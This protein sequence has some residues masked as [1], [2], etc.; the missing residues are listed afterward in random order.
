MAPH[1]LPTTDVYCPSASEGDQVCG[2]Q[3]SSLYVQSFLRQT[4]LNKT[5]PNFAQEPPVAITKI[6]AHPAPSWTSTCFIFT[7]IISRFI[8]IAQRTLLLGSPRL[9]SFL[10]TYFSGHPLTWSPPPVAL[11]S[12]DVVIL[13]HSSTI[14]FWGWSFSARVLLLLRSLVLLVVVGGWTS[15]QTPTVFFPSNSNVGWLLYNA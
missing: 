10:F 13:L 4:D 6:A 3:S 8:E 12:I 9:T 7:L 5:I 2:S 14:R 11:R 1:I 15:W